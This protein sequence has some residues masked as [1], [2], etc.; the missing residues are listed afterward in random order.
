MPDGLYLLLKFTTSIGAVFAMSLYMRGWG[1]AHQ[2][3][4]MQFLKTLENYQKKMTF[5]NKKALQKYDF[6]FHA[7]PV[8]YRATATNR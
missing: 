8:E 2:P 4:Y 5:D 6:E 1:R 7:W 3:V